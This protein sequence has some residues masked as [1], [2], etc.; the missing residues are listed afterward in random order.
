MKKDT[1]I[2]YLLWCAGLLGVCGL[3][4]FYLGQTGAGILYLLTLGL[5]GIGQL[6]D[7]FLIP[8]LAKTQNER[9]EASFPVSPQQNIIVNVGEHIS[10]KTTTSSDQRPTALTPARPAEVQRKKSL[11]QRILEACATKPCSIA[12]LIIATGEPMEKVKQVTETLATEGL[13]HQTISETGSV[14]YEVH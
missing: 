8:G 13:L 1:G 4:R 5:C 2:A 7:L 6:V 12:H 3:Q 9:S 14:L 11:E 10:S